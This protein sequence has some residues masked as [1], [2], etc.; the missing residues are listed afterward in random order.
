M[1]DARGYVCGLTILGGSTENRPSSA[2]SSGINGKNACHV[3]AQGIQN[4]SK[5]APLG[6]ART[7]MLHHVTFML[8]QALTVDGL[9]RTYRRR[10]GL[11]LRPHRNT[12]S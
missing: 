7:L 9:A 6:L 4:E 2:S 11:G 12:R 1:Y 10:L 3:S 5:I 8:I